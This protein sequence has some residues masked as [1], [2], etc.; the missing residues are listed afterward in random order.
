MPEHEHQVYETTS[1]NPLSRR[2]D[3]V[4]KQ[5]DWRDPADEQ[6]R[7][8]LFRLCGP[9]AGRIYADSNRRRISRAPNWFADFNRGAAIDGETGRLVFFFSMAIQCTIPERAAIV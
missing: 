4:G 2:R 7:R 1:L 8:R 6:L 9:F 5:S 3:E